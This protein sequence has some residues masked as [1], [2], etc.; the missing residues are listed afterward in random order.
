VW[1][2]DQLCGGEERYR[3]TQMPRIRCLQSKSN[4]QLG[5]EKRCPTECEW[6][7]VVQYRIINQGR[8]WV[9]TGDSTRN[10]MTENEPT[11][12]ST[13]GLGRF[14][15]LAWA[16][17]TVRVG[18]PMA[19]Q[20]PDE[21]AWKSRRSASVGRMSDATAAGA[22]YACATWLRSVQ[23]LLTRLP[24]PPVVPRNSISAFAVASAC[25]SGAAWPAPAISVKS[26]AAGRPAT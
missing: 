5:P 24:A 3:V 21:E 25:S 4:M 14:E 9:C 6:P 2:L 10:N 8:S 7:K 18:P 22:T 11:V 17:R 20:P 1:K 23:P 12:F 26:L 16:L 13:L 15:R 19:V